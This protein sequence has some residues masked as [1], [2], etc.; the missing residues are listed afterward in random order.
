MKQS[1]LLKAGA[2]IRKSHKQFKDLE[3]EVAGKAGFAKLR[4][5]DSKNGFVWVDGVR[6]A[7]I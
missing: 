2:F 7:L 6:V 3:G 1:V 4:H 5:F